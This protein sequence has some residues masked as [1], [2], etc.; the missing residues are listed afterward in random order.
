M[1]SYSSYKKELLEKLVSSSG[2]PRECGVWKATGTRL[3]HILPLGD[4]PE[5]QNT[6]ANRASAIKKY[7]DFDCSDCLIGLKG[8]HQYAHHLNSSQLLCMMFF[9]SL[10]DDKGGAKKEMVKF[11]KDAFGIQIHEGA[12]CQFEYTEKKDDIYK[13][14]VCG[15][16]EYE[17]T[18]FDFHIKDDDTEIYFEIKFTEDGFGKAD[19]DERHEKKASQY[20]ALLPDFYKSKVKDTDV[21]NHYQIF[22]NIVRADK[23]NKYVIFIT[24]ENNPLTNKEIDIFKK[25]FGKPNNVKFEFWQE[26]KDKYPY[27]LPFQFNALD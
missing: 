24:D 6:P 17:G 25:D 4:N 21:L 1:K 3:P 10:I 15:K 20:K 26:V 27:S 18:N 9:R 22:R 7:L 8:L 2:T 16:E 12:C 5:T 19:K 14:K 13:F 11:I 23:D